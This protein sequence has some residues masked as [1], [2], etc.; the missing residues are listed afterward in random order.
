LLNNERRNRASHC[1]YKSSYMFRLQ[2]SL[3]QAVR[4]RSIKGNYVPVV[5]MQLQTVNGRDLILTCKGVYDCY[6]ERSIRCCVPLNTSDMDS[7]F[8]VETCSC[9]DWL[10]CF[11]YC[12]F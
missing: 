11:F 5:Y 3:R 8:A 1:D 10:Y 12:I 4:V 9:I 6:T 7:Y 2:S